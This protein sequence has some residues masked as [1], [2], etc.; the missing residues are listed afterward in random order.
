MKNSTFQN[1]FISEVN[2]EMEK[3]KNSINELWVKY[4]SGDID[5]KTHTKMERPYTYNLIR[6]MK[7]KNQLQDLMD[8]KNNL[9]ISK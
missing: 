5:E 9:E 1:V 8:Y 6:L 2:K 3:I 4:E 7:I